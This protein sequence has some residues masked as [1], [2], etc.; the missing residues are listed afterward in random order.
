MIDALKPILLLNVF[1]FSYAFSAP[2][3]KSPFRH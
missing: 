2:S 3:F 1:I